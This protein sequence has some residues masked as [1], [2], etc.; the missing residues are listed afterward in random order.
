MG[1]T[2]FFGRKG[3]CHAGVVVN[4]T[5]NGR[6]SETT[7]AVH[8]IDKLGSECWFVSALCR[9][10]WIYTGEGEGNDICQLLCS[11]EVS[12]QS[13]PLWAMLRDK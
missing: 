1:F 2:P 9:W 6:S 10:S 12:P 8:V 7:W 4:I 13:L 11:Y 3:S 5:G